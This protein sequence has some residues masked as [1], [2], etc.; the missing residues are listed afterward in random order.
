MLSS[1]NRSR[2]LTVL[3]AVGSGCARA[4]APAPAQSAE[5]AKPA[6]SSAADR[7]EAAARILLDQLIL[8]SPESISRLGI[9]GHDTEILDLKPKVDERFIA[10]MADATKRLEAEAAKETDP[11]V[12][13]DLAIV[14]KAAQNYARG[15]ELEEKLLVPFEPIHKRVYIGVNGLLVDS[16]PAER[17]KAA[18]V[19]VRRYAA[20]EE[21]FEPIVDLAIART[22]EKL[23]RRELAGP[24]R[25]EVEKYLADAPT[26]VR[27]M[28]ELFTKYLDKDALEPLSKLET[29]LS[30]Y[31]AF[32]REQVLPRARA[33]FRTPEELYRFQLQRNGIDLTPEE[34]AAKAR[35]SFAETQKEMQAL[36]AEIAKSRG[37][38]KSDYR[39]VLAELKK[40]QIAGDDLLHLYERRIDDMNAIIK[41]ENLVSLPDRPMRFRFAS[42]AETA[43]QPAPHV[44]PQGLF[45]RKK[46]VQLAFVLPLAV[47][48]GDDKS[49]RYDDFN[50]EAA[51]WT[52]TAHEGRPGH[53]LQLSIIAERGLSL[54]RT[55]FA[56][57]STNV[58][59]WALYAEK[60]SRPFMPPEGRFVSLQFLLLREA[61]AFLDPELQLGKISIQDARKV[62]EGDVGLSTAN[63]TQEL[64]RYT[65]N[66]PGQAPCYFYGYL[67]TL[68][69]RDEIE[70][71][72][73]D[74]FDAKLFHD[75]L[76][77]Q[78]LL[79]P[80]LMSKAVREK[81]VR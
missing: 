42:A 62:L 28:R 48:Q 6:P 71:A 45:S 76:L 33:D 31:E 43:E 63:A 11:I 80:D 36:A 53:D 64:D 7:S 21:G 14:L 44:D 54:A 70:H 79:P 9:E 2:A 20:L 78:G 57:N 38:K 40:K 52:L 58:E 32:A 8:F 24:V 4:P 41:K 22:K 77:A 18:L 75:T 1:P 73:G 35:A 47:K 72:M 60:I 29:Q 81:L 37:L 16:L 26:Y 39:H 30:R 34:L 15:A 59:G 23:D 19:R 74:R 5:P 25:A 68:A 50:Y 55:M 27:G 67:R 49:L 3:I 66:M 65:F 12:A 51:S 13:Q 10:A 56:F 69:L 17:R 46:G 61:R